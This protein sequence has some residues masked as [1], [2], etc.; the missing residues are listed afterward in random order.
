[1]DVC[2]RPICKQDAAVIIAGRRFILPLTLMLLLVLS[3]LPARAAERWEVLPPTPAPVTSAHSGQAEANGISVHYAIYGQGS[4]VILLHGGLANMEYWGQQIEALAPHHTV[5]VMDSRGH[6]GST[7]DSRPYSY[8]LMTDDVVALMDVLKV[9]KA[10]I[11]GW[12]DGG[13]IGLDLAMRYPERVGKIVAFAA[14]TMTSGV[15]DGMEKN[16]TFAAFIER[17]GHEYE[18]HSATPNDYNAFV[19]QIGKMWASQPNWT[20]AQLKAITAPV[21]VVDGDHD[22]AVKREHTEHIAAT[23]PGAGLLILP[24]VSHFAFLQDP[25]LFNYAALHFLDDQ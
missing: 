4:P 18:T 13:I 25:G 5:I 8:D 19:E 1:M 7:S 15:I 12:S 20:D 14:N 2:S 11:V 10:D 21:L 6:G 24:N 23:I 17:A 9:P 3:V 22:E 16:P